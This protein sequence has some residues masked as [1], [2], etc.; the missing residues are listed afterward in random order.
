M[1]TDKFYV[2]VHLKKAHQGEKCFDN[3]NV[4]SRMMDNVTYSGK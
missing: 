4:V 2:L 1:Q 3:G